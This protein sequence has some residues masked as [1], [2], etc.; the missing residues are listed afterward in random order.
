MK[1]GTRLAALEMIRSGTTTFV[2]M[3]YFEDQVAEACDEAGMRV[4]RSARRSSS[5]PRPTTRRSPDALAY[6]ETF[7]KRWAG[8]PAA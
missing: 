6:A 5:S 1:A 8:R 4:R 7:L 2:D 3:Y